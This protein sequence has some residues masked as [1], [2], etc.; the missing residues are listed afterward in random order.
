MGKCNNCPLYMAIEGGNEFVDGFV[1]D[2]IDDE[3]KPGHEILKRNRTYRTLYGIVEKQIT[4]HYDDGPEDVTV[5]PSVVD[6]S[7]EEVAA[8]EE[9][10]EVQE[11]VATETQQEEPA[12]DEEQVASSDMEPVQ[13][14]NKDDDERME[15]LI[16]A[17]NAAKNA[18][19]KACLEPFNELFNLTG[20]AGEQGQIV[21]F[22]DGHMA[23][24]TIRAKRAAEQAKIKQPGQYL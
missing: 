6:S 11:T 16:A 10:S 17:L 13:E 19:K 1:A 21:V 4:C 23:H 5:Q 9:P 18:P 3:R 8:L 24:E 15:A 14:E 2:A 12:A 22:P 7:V 20:L